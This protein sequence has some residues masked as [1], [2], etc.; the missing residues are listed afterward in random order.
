MD[1]TDDQAVTHQTS[2]VSAL[3]YRRLFDTTADG[4]LIVDANT[5]KIS[6]VNPALAVLTGLPVSAMVG[7]LM[8][9][10]AP[11]KAIVP[12][13]AQF[14]ELCQQGGVR[15]DYIPLEMPDGRHVTLECAR[16]ACAFD[17]GRVIHYT[18]RDVTARQQAEKE[19]QRRQA[20]LER[21]L[22]VYQALEM[23]F[24]EAQKMDVLGQ[25]ASGVA[26]DFNNL[27]AV[28]MGYTEL[29]TAD[30]GPESTLRKYTEEIWRASECAAGLANQ[31]LIF[32]RKQTVQA[33]VLDLNAVVNDLVKMLRRLIGET[34]DLAIVA[35][36]QIGHVK[37]DAG[38][39]CQVLMNIVVNSR[40]AMPHGGRLTIATRNV[41]L[42]E[43]DVSAPAGVLPGDYV[44]LTVTDTGMGMNKQIQARLF[45]AFFTTKPVG[46]GTGLG[47]ATCQTIVRQFGGHIGVSSEPG[48]GAAFTVY[49]PRVEQ[50]LAAV[51]NP[52][53]GP[54][55]R[56]TETLLFVEDEPAVR[57]MA[58]GVLEGLGY[59]VLPA[60][61]G[62]D[63]LNV[64]RE[65][66]GAPIRLV[67]TDVIMPV[68]GGKLM[69]EWLKTA[70]PNLKILFTSGYTD[71]VITDQG[72]QK[73]RSEFLPKPYT[74]AALAGKVREILDGG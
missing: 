18:V 3:R 63:A 59:E 43:T 40:D 71:D 64:A 13:P 23:K 5:G 33:V 28:I 15:H 39:V 47:L 72:V 62:Q 73:T 65:H 19:R 24:V 22:M 57:H 60:A 11:F 48:K 2:P 38:H 34:I 54:P 20:E 45:E 4:M 29:L 1:T 56:G 31:L 35:E 32:S 27:L 70:Y 8:W 67:V 36:K 46:K 12:S 49:F 58:C 10:L 30:L 68:M 25:L 53:P 69:A 61:N 9:E 6:D 55:D 74:T 17:D 26:H 42:H 51:T 66:D 21:R 44:T 41:S 14:A 16:Q 7:Q 37:A 50:P 52:P